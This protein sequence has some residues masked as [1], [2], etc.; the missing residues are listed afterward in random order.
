MNNATTHPRYSRRQGGRVVISAR[1]RRT[2]GGRSWG[3]QHSGMRLWLYVP[4]DERQELWILDARHP[5]GGPLAQISLKALLRSVRYVEGDHSASL[6]L[7]AEAPG[8]VPRRRKRPGRL[9]RVEIDEADA[10]SGTVFEAPWDVCEVVLLCKATAVDLVEEFLLRRV[11]VQ[12]AHHQ[13]CDPG[14]V[15]A[16]IL[17]AFLP[18]V[19]NFLG[20]GLLMRGGLGH[21]SS[22]GRR[23]SGRD[24]VDFGRLCPAC[25][26]GSCRKRLDAW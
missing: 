26:R 21:H 19:G 11:D 18:L 25:R 9:R 1:L 6:V 8:V 4:E 3:F 5:C 23:G 16:P 7:H 2:G 14:L 24:T 12:V 17:L 20:L 10:F 13:S 22:G 15:G